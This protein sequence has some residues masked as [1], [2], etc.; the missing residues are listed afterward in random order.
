[1]N[2]HEAYDTLGL[3]ESASSEDVNKAFRKLA[4]QYHPDL[5]KDNEKESEAKFKKI[6]EAAQTIKNPPPSIPNM[7]SGWHGDMPDW[8]NIPMGFRNFRRQPKPP[9]RADLKIS[10]K[11]SVLG[12]SKDINFTRHNKCSSCNGM[13]SILEVGKCDKCNGRGVNQSVHQSAN[14]RFQFVTQCDKCNGSGRKSHS[15]TACSGG[16]IPEQVTHRVTVPGG[17]HNGDHVRLANAGNFEGNFISDVIISVSVD[18]D[19]DMVLNESGRD[20]LSTIDLSLLEALKGVKR[21]VR[22]V[23]GDLTLNI[24]AGIKNGNTIK[25]SGYGSRGLG[26]HLFTININYPSDTTSLVELLENQE[27]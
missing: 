5:N 11:E 18:S 15:C 14:S 8:V 23:K 4:A 3:E 22:T 20:V 1:M 13:G 25:A 27:K 26:D 19:S 10:F 2:L 6:N 17:L 7:P 16:G 21:K 24:R 9:P 12:C